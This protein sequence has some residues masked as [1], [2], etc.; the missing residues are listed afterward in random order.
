MHRFDAGGADL[1]ADAVDFGPLE[2]GMLAGPVGRIIV[3]TK[4]DAVAAHL[5]SFLA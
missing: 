5:G 3:A 1:R 4:Q 2:I